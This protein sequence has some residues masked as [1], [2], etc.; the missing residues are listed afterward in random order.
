MLLLL[1]RKKYFSSFAGALCARIFFFRGRK[2]IAKFAEKSRACQQKSKEKKEE[3]GNHQTRPGMIEWVWSMRTVSREVLGRGG[4]GGAG[5]C[6]R[7]EDIR[8]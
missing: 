4:W 3:K 2:A 6:V 7:F 8:A 1:L 5:T